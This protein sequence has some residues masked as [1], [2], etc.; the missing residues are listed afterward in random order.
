MVATKNKEEFELLQKM[1][2]VRKTVIEQYG[3]RGRSNPYLRPQITKSGVEDLA[4]LDVKEFTRGIIKNRPDDKDYGEQIEGI[5]V[6]DIGAKL[7]PKYYQ[8]AIEDPTELTQN[9]LYAQAMDLKQSVG[10][11]H[12]KLAEKD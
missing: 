1:I 5:N 8:N 11:K 7:I 6:R 2:G 12:K 4:T 3:D 9:I 10:Y